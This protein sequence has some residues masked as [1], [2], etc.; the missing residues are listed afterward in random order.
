M[1]TIHFPKRNNPGLFNGN[2]TGHIVRSSATPDIYTIAGTG[3]TT[4]DAVREIYKG[5]V[6]T[7]P[8]L[9]NAST[10]A[11]DLLISFPLA[12]P[13]SNNVIVGDT[14]QQLLGKRLI[15]T[16]A[17][18]SG[19]ATWFLLRRNNTTALNTS[20]GIIGTVGVLGSGADLEVPNTAI[21]QGQNYQSAG[22]NLSWLL[23]RTV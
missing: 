11:A 13:N 10:V 7:F 19:V 21:V 15:D 6:P 2:N 9:T 16:A 23:T 5:T 20:G 22:F 18:A 3:N 17:T 14:L 1:A 12:N 8:A 4:P